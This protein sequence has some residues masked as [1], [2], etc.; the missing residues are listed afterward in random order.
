MAVNHPAG[1]EPDRR[2]PPAAPRPDRSGD[3]ANAAG[4]RVPLRARRGG[5]DRGRAQ[6]G[7]V[8]L[9]RDGPG[10]AP[11]ARSGAAG[12]R[13]GRL[14][15][16]EGPDRRAGRARGDRPAHG[17]ELRAHR[18]PRARGAVRLPAVAP[19]R[20]RGHRDGRRRP[21][22]DAPRMDGRRHGRATGRAAQGVGLPTRFYRH[23][24]ARGRGRRCATTRRPGTA[25]CPSS[26]CR[27]TGAGGG[28]LTTSRWTWSSRSCGRSSDDATPGQGQRRGSRCEGRRGDWCC[29]FSS[30]ERLWRAATGPTGARTRSSARS[31][32]SRSTSRPARTSC[33]G[34]PPGSGGGRRVLPGPGRSSDKGGQLVDGALVTVTHDAGV[35]LP[36]GTEDFVGHQRPTTRGIAH[37]RDLVRE[38]GARHRHHHRHRG[39]RMRP[40]YHRLLGGMTT[41]DATA[42]RRSLRTGRGRWWPRGAARRSSCCAGIL[43]Q[44]CSDNN[45]TRQADARS[46]RHGGPERRTRPRTA[47]PLPSGLPPSAL[48]R[49]STAAARGERAASSSPSANGHRRSR[50][51]RQ[52]TCRRRSLDATSGVTGQRPVLDLG[53]DPRA[54]TDGGDG[55]GVVDGACTDGPG[56]ASAAPAAHR[57]TA[58]DATARDDEVTAA[59]AHVSTTVLGFE[60]AVGLHGDHARRRAEEHGDSPGDFDLSVDTSSRARRLHVPRE[61]EARPPGARPRDSSPASDRRVGSAAGRSSWNRSR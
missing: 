8:R 19:R 55:D 42:S 1:Q 22:G 58:V 13:G 7:S 21:P 32:A 53:L 41:M 39:G 27:D 51:S 26:S 43:V 48:G 54:S 34:R 57:P 23:R 60:R 30:S 4:A 50:A 14:L 37:L 59:A 15:R 16:G 5:Q 12:G 3:A 25:A 33:A 20:G 38:G 10:R 9:A 2:L 18:R 45:G 35:L 28:L 31:R 17:A 47:S 24:A 61:R 6:R 56:S 49:R 46:R 44:G 29:A 52:L 11:A 36:A 40:F